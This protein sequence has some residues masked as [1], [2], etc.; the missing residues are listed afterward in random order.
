MVAAFPPHLAGVHASA[1]SGGGSLVECGG[2]SLPR[3]Y[4]PGAALCGRGFH[5]RNDRPGRF[6]AAEPPIACLTRWLV[7]E[8]RPPVTSPSGLSSLIVPAR[9]AQPA[10]YLSCA[11]C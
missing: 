1:R 5:R 9:M 8:E 10:S 6:G 11:S 3:R 7:R 4:G 2:G